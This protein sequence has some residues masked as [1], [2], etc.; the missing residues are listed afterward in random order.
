[1][2]NYISPTAKIGENVVIEPFCVIKGDCVIGDGAVIESFCYL[3]NATIGKGSI[4]R[5]SRITDSVVGDNVTVGPYAHLRGGAVVSDSCRVG[6]FVE[7]KHSRLGPDTKAAHLAYI[8]DATVG[9]NCN[10]GCGVIFVNYDGKSKHHTTVGD[11]CFI[12]CNSNIIAPREIGSNTF[13]ACDTTVDK[14]VPD[15]AFAIGR[16]KVSIKENYAERYLK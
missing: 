14:D 6:N 7:I 1:M 3:D 8:G 16:S 12:G 2:D 15:G 9:N 10:V 13:I 11:N 4:I 5:Q